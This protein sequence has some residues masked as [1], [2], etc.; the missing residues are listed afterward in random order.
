METRSFGKT[1]H[2]VSV[3]GFGSAP[4]GYLGADQQRVAKILNMMLDAGVNLLDTAASY[5]GSEEMIAKTVGD[6]RG[7]FVLVSKC[8]GKLPDLP[9]AAWSPELITKTIERSL[10]NLATDHLDV[11]LLHSCS[12]DKLQAGGGIEPLV[13]AGAAGKIRFVGCRGDNE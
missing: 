2:T 10:K 12:L 8:G 7:E 4:M 13:K 6:R 3:L 1:G 5:P 11:M 9:D